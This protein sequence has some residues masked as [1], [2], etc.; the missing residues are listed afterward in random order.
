M[1]RKQWKKAFLGPYLIG[2]FF[3]SA[4]VSADLVV[5]ALVVRVIVATPDPRG[6]STLHPLV[7]IIQVISDIIQ[8]PVMAA[9]KHVRSF[10]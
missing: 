4:D 1:K 9:A 8:D 7:Q 6:P 10:T 2:E 5:Q 3:L